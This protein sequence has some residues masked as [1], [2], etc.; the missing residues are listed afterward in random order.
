MTDAQKPRTREELIEDLAIAYDFDNS[1]R[2]AEEKAVELYNEIRASV[3]AELASQ[4]PVGYAHK[5]AIH[6]LKNGNAAH[7]RL[8]PSNT[9]NARLAALYA[10]PMP[11][12]DQTAEVERLR[13]VLDGIEVYASDTLAGP[14]DGL[15]DTTWYLEGV[16]EIRARARAALDAPQPETR[17][18]VK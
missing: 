5:P 12:A 17:E 11:P 14:A 1:M 9:N 3:L 18:C 8:F 2:I 6:A 7:I 15:S 4:E 16:R 10:Q 13:D